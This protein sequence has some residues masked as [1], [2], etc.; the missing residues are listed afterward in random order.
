M[1]KE[2]VIL[3]V[4]NVIVS[5]DFCIPRRLDRANLFLPIAIFHVTLVIIFPNT[6]KAGMGLFGWAG[7]ETVLLVCLLNDL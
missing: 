4:H 6:K 3:G 7:E 2:F 5:T 1:Q